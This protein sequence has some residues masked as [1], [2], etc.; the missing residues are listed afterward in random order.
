M[1]WRGPN[2]D[3]ENPSLGWEV[4][5]WAEATFKVPDGPFAGAPLRLTDEQAAILVRFYWLDDR[6]HFL[7]RRGAV[8]RPQGWG[9]SPLLAL[10]ALAELCGPTRFDGWDAAGEPVARPPSTPWVQIA[11]VSEDQ[12]DNTYAA[13][14]TM[15]AESD[16]AGTTLDVGLTRVFLR[17]E[18]G[19][20]EPVTAAAGTRLGQRV[21][22]AVLDEPH[23]W[24]KRNGG[25]KLAATI[26][27][28]AGKMG[29]RTFE[30]TNAHL[31]GEDSVAERTYK[32]HVTGAAGL[33]Y[34]SVEGPE[35]DDLTD[36]PAVL[37]SLRIAYGDARWVD[38]ERLADE[39]ADPGTD[40]DDARR[41]YLNQLV[42][43]ADRPVDIRAWEALADPTRTVE[44]GTEIGVG[45]DGSI[46]NDKTCLYG[47]TRDGHVF[48]I[49]VWERPPNAPRD[50]RI[51]RLEVHAA[52]RET[53]ATYRVGRMLCDPPKWYT[54]I[55]GWQAEFNPERAEDAIV[56]V[57]DTNQARR[58]AP[59]CDRFAS[60]AREEFLSHDGKPRLTAA[61]AACS[62][63]PVRLA[64]D[65]E[66]GRSRF[67]IVKADTRKI[68]EAV[69]A[70]LAVEAAMTMPEYVDP[71]SAYEDRGLLVL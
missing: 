66:D 32:A 71:T 30:S 2:Y 3:G 53:F 44:P 67:V 33:L 43:G 50:W 70:T 45:F 23:L 36:R 31:P 56:L 8:R 49:A 37:A 27:R 26:R 68:D 46:S 51:P 9:K 58:F 20:L 41:F 1:P 61:L 24:T 19:R 11:A 34:D 10:V 7:F 57:L 62:K 5:D 21:T 42:V 59:A 14:H 25:H 18:T 64:D 17:G 60:L 28:N 65:P 35:V 13:L 22:F 39:I 63:Q 40:P 4:L 29:G 55:E 48:E 69:G 52:V 54:E 6:G 16:L 12:T 47:C 15:A 38:L